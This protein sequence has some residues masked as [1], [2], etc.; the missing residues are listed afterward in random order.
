MLKQSNETEKGGHRIISIQDCGEPLVTLEGISPRIKTYP[1]YYLHQVPHA[2]EQCFLREGAAKRLVEA[3]NYLPEGIDLLVLDAWRPFEVQHALYEMIR[4]EL[5]QQEGMTEEKLVSE[6]SKFVARP[7]EDVERPSP[8][9]TGGAVDV[10]LVNSSGW[11]NMGTQFDEF[12]EKARA[13]YYENLGTLSDEEITIKQ[14]RQLLQSVMNQVGFTGYEEEWW[15]FNFGNP[16]W[17]RKTNS[18]AIYK[19]IRKTS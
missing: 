4:E 10:T 3:A 5:R 18:I 11:L 1:Y 15:H 12:S 19:G 13:D 14:N 9:M 7:S 6:L 2:L 16:S 8:H 17:A